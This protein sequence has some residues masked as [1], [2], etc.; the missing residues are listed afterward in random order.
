MPT[1]AEA[2]FPGLWMEGTQGLFGWRGMPEPQREAWSA[3][4]REVLAEPAVAER[5]RAAG[6]AARGSTPAEF[7]RFL[8]EHRARGA[9]LAR[10]FGAR[11]P[12]G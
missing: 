6:M 12:G 9:A 5:L 2:A 10:E 11:P 8:D 3:V 7:G 4:A 1:S